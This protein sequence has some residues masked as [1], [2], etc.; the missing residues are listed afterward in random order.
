MSVSPG[1]RLGPYEVVSPLAAGGMGEIYRARDP[2][3]GRPVAVKVLRST[4]V[5]PERLRRFKLEAQAAGMLNHPNV[6]S[7]YDVGT[8][9]GAPYLVTEFLEGDTLRAMLRVGPLPATKAVDYAI[10][11]AQGLAAAHAKGIV[12]R[13]LKPDNLLVTRDARLKI[14]DFGLAKLTEPTVPGGDPNEA[15]TLDPAYRL[16]EVVGT[17][18]YQSPEQVRGELVDHRSDIFSFGAVL[19]EMLTGRRA[20][21]GASAADTMSATLREDPLAAVETDAWPSGLDLIV[22][23]CLEKE[24]ERR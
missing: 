19:L 5:D 22:Q 4:A 3:L 8:H 12:H 15:S 11:I 16:G 10:Q 14:L 17:L 2:R 18:C 7:V 23:H 24:P 13:D 1:T 20:F 21:Q 9:D 6:L